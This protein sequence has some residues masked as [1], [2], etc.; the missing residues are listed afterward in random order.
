MVVV[1]VPVL[2]IR[3]VLPEHRR[4]H[5]RA[6]QQLFL[7]LL[8]RSVLQQCHRR[9]LQSPHLSLYHPSVGCSA[10]MPPRKV[11][12]GETATTTRRTTTGVM[13]VA[14]G[15]SA[16][17]LPPRR[18]FPRCSGPSLRIP[19]LRPML[20][21]VAATFREDS[22][23]TPMLLVRPKRP[24]MSLPRPRPHPLLLGPRTSR[25]LLATPS[26]WQR[27]V[28]L[29]EEEE[30]TRTMAMAMETAADTEATTRSPPRPSS[31]PP[32][33]SLPRPCPK[34]SLG[35]TG[36]GAIVC[37]WPPT[38]ET[39]WRRRLPRPS[40]PRTRSRPIRL[41]SRWEACWPFWT[42]CPAFPQLPPTPGRHPMPC[43]LLTC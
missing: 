20:L 21:L 26:A 18:S 7:L 36:R 19:S 3:L 30:E 17:R 38:R 33:R 25:R 5:L 27:P 40:L 1:A 15:V 2:M 29:E 43:C 4:R 8:Q 41:P 35:T 34:S 24:R 12:Q 14:P 9:R 39:R 16:R 11:Q 22:T 23:S 6:H 28:V 31:L 10:L 32:F 37:S 13:A 42:N